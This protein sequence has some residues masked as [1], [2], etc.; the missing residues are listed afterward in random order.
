MDG[1]HSSSA[2]RPKSEWVLKLNQILVADKSLHTPEFL[3]TVN[4]QNQLNRASKVLKSK[5]KT[6]IEY[7]QACVDY[8]NALHETP[9]DLEV[10]ALPLD[11]IIKLGQLIYSQGYQPG[12]FDFM[13][14]GIDVTDQPE[15]EEIYLVR[16]VLRYNNVLHLIESDGDAMLE[17]IHYHPIGS[18]YARGSRRDIIHARMESIGVKNVDADKLWS[19]VLR[20]HYTIHE[21]A[22]PFKDRRGTEPQLHAFAEG[23]VRDDKYAIPKY[24]A[25]LALCQFKA[26]KTKE[27]YETAMKGI[28]QA[29]ALDYSFTACT[30]YLDALEAVVHGALAPTFTWRHVAELLEKAEKCLIDSK[31]AAWM[32]NAQYDAVVEQIKYWKEAKTTE[33]SLTEDDDQLDVEIVC[34]TDNLRRN[35]YFGKSHVAKIK[36]ERWCSNCGKQ[37]NERLLT[38]GRCKSAFYCSKDC[39]TA[40]WREHKRRCKAPVSLV[41]DN[42]P[43]DLVTEILRQYELGNFS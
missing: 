41:E 3:A 32:P 11:H 43:F 23:L 33:F 39:Q 20:N 40:H 13:D 5:N 19:V 31:A 24:S 10:S 42:A 15:I 36:A 22:K 35:K 26:G 27:A 29:L 25:L 2:Q 34:L 38:C 8:L 18:H 4:A 12:R 6:L 17:Q 7:L 30:L 28:E 21:R 1:A 16:A 37:C 9:T 14:T